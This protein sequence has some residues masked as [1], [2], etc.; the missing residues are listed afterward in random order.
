MTSVFYPTVII[1]LAAMRRLTCLLN[2]QV[3]TAKFNFMK[4]CNFLAFTGGMLAGGLVMMM[5]APKKGEEVRKDIKERLGDLKRHFDNAGC[6]GKEGC[7]C[8]T[9]EKIVIEE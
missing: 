7:D 6:C 5:F 4:V 9:E 1:F 2:L 3:L 8:K